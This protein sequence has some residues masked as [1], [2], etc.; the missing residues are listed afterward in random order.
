[1]ES[2]PVKQSTLLKLSQNCS[3]QF[4][5]NN[6]QLPQNSRLHLKSLVPLAVAVKKIRR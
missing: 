1:M 6:L 3:Y 2:I 4:Y 5:F